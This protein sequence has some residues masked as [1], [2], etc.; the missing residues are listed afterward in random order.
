MPYLSV[1]EIELREMIISW[2]GIQRSLLFLTKNEIEKRV[3]GVKL[4]QEDK[5]SA[6]RKIER[7]NG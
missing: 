7:E 1:S 2:L 3:R 6:D 5:E 4:T